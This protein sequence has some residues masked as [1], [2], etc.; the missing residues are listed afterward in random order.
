MLDE[1]FNYQTPNGVHGFSA[2]VSSKIKLSCLTVKY[3]RKTCFYTGRNMN[4]RTFYF[5]LSVSVLRMQNCT[6]AESWTPPHPFILF[7]VLSNKAHI[8][9]KIIQQ[10]H[11]LQATTHFT[12]HIIGI[13]DL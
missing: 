7:A 5:L 1:I 8:V 12:V 13:I 9:V 6:E 2:L 11:F 4:I 3:Q 10:Q